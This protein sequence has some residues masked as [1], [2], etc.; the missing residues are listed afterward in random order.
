MP[1]K[2]RKHEHIYT[3]LSRY[4]E[5]TGMITARCDCGAETDLAALAAQRRKISAWSAHG[6]GAVKVDADERRITDG[7]DNHGGWAIDETD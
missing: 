1:P 6:A 4:D 7:D 3:S 5:E 2:T